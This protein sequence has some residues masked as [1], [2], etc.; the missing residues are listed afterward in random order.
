MRLSCPSPSWNPRQDT[1]IFMPEVNQAC[2]VCRGLHNSIEEEVRLRWL[3]QIQWSSPQLGVNFELVSVEQRFQ[4][5]PQKFARV[6]NE[7][8]EATILQPRSTLC[9]FCSSPVCK[10]AAFPAKTSGRGRD[11]A[12]RS[13]TTAMLEHLMLKVSCLDRMSRASCHVR[14]VP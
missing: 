6:R 12:S 10:A 11:K 9:G 5:A 2:F 3:I 13:A 4:D 14:Y 7:S 8:L 1:V